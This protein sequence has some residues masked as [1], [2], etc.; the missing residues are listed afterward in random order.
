[1]FVVMELGAAGEK[2]PPFIP[3]SASN[4]GVTDA[5]RGAP[6]APLPQC[7]TPSSGYLHF[8]NCLNFG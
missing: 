6:A 2:D 1:M 7:A 5:V 8:P 4:S 3:A